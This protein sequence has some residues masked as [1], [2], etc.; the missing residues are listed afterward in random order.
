MTA[1]VARF[2]LV[3]LGGFVVQLGVLDALT[4]LIALDYR[5]ATV[6]A[7]EAAILQLHVA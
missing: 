1:R 7:V 4:R 6:L 2:A 5:A 3:G